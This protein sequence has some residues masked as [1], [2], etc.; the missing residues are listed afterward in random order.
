LKRA[1]L[2]LTLAVVMV[3]AVV[4]A[5]PDEV[6][7][8]VLNGTFID[9][10]G[11]VHEN[12]IEAVALAGITVGC[13]PPTNNRFCPTRNVTRAEAATF[14]ARALGLPSDGED[15]FVDDNGHVLEGGI[16]RLAAVGITQ[17]CNPPAND[18]FCPERNLTRAEFAAF[19]AR[20]LA[21]P[22]SSIDHFVDD[23]G[24]VLE[25]S[26]NRIA[27]A[28]ITLGC[29]PPAN[30]RFCPNRLLTRGET[31]TLLTRALSLPH[32]PV[33]LP[34]ANWS[35]ISCGKDGKGCSVT[36]ETS[37]GR[38]HLVEEGFFNRL[39]YRSGEE[40]QLM[41]S[42]TSFTLTLD[43][44]A[45]ALTQLPITTSSTQAV[46][47]WNAVL[48]FTDGSHVLV[49]EWRWNGSLIQ[50]TTASISAG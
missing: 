50:R 8:V 17:G 49:G 32:N 3:I 35:A 47:S 29:N 1:A 48:T 27:D 46:R 41:A 28:G 39:P 22:P 34:L 33:R 43:G 18:R 36:I 42:G 37:G 7:A 11:S 40:S 15:Y 16:N 23:D 6:D 26:I 4:I 10:N 24:H 12:G 25:S 14:L 20:G 19:I 13:N 2:P 44:Q 5:W 21:L 9:D 30:T 45:V 38:A 31:A